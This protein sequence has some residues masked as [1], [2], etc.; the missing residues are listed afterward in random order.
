MLFRSDLLEMR[1]KVDSDLKRLSEDFPSNREVIA[2]RLEREMERGNDE[3]VEI[4]LS[5]AQKMEDDNR[6]WRAKAWLLSLRVE[7]PKAKEACDEAIRL[8]PMDWQ[9]FLLR[10]TVFRQL[11]NLAAAEKDSKIGYQGSELTQQL[12]SS[13]KVFSLESTFYERLASFAELCDQSKI[14]SNIRVQ[15]KNYVPSVTPNEPK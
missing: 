14:A 6:L 5:G 7:N 13:S 1:M 3:A 4:L 15:L 11:G 9:A 8:V 2:A 12:N 10:A